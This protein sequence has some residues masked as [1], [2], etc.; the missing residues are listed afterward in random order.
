MTYIGGPVPLNSGD[1]VERVFER[2]ARQR[3][4]NREWVLLLGPRQHGK[5]SA[6]IRLRR[7]LIEQGYRCAFVDLQNLPAQY[8]FAR[9]LEWFCGQIGNGTGNPLH[10]RPGGSAE[11]LEEW[12]ECV[13]PPGAP[14]VVLIDEA[15]SIRDELIRNAFYG[16][17]RALKSTSAEKPESVAARV[18][19]LF[20]GTFRPETLVEQKNSPFNVCRRIDTEDLTEANVT[21]LAK[22][23]LARDDVDAIARTVV[24]HVGGQPH[25]VQSLLGAAAIAEPAEQEAAILAEME[26]W[27]SHSNDH[28]DSLFRMVLDDTKLMNI[29]AAAVAQGNVHND[30][31]NV[32][33]KFIVVI[34]LLQRDGQY[35]RFRNSLYETI[36]KASP[37]LRPEIAPASEQPALFFH[38]D[39]AVFQFITDPQYRE[40]CQSAYNGAVTAWNGG[41]YRL[42]LV[43]FGCALEAILLDL[44]VAT[45]PAQI[46]G[47]IN[48]TPQAGRP[49]FNKYESQANPATWRLVNLMRV[50]RLMNRARGPLEL[51]DSLREM[52][53]FVHPSVMKQNY[54]PEHDLVPEAQAAGALIAAVMRDVQRP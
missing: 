35:L 54:L 39:A 1:Y 2:E 30:P 14:L 33:Y 53:N 16:Q 41:S 11:S 34:G 20:A 29:A 43:G 47:I 22:V 15:S 7:S 9:L 17:I 21:A 52:R 36:A 24:A 3:L 50:A 5:T 38:L 6:L 37:Q 42:T 10:T 4:A 28:L 18:V 25:L 13:V 40:I 45:P 49:N 31:A 19:F 23:A 8:E 51:P 48:A 46:T 32:D 27:T 44:M 26:R 12:L